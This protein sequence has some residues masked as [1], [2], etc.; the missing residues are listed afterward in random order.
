MQEMRV[1]VNLVRSTCG[2]L[3][4][5][6]ED[7]ALPMQALLNLSVELD[8]GRLCHICSTALRNSVPGFA[9]SLACPCAVSVIYPR[10]VPPPPADCMHAPVCALLARLHNLLRPIMLHGKEIALRG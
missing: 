8:H 3:A 1:N 9:F 4:H 10:Y 5:H 7:I 6:Q 2:S